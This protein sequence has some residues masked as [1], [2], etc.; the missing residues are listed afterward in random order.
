FP[1]T[2]I[3]RA[4]LEGDDLSVINAGGPGP[5]EISNS[6]FITPSPGPG[7]TWQGTMTCTAVSRSTVFA[8][9]GCP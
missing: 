9:S 1:S 3:T 8:G 7:Q 2:T 4:T 5:V 6:R